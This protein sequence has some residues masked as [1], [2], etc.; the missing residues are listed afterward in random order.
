MALVFALA[1]LAHAVP[2]AAQAG[3]DV[4]LYCKTRC[5]NDY[6]GLDVCYAECIQ[7]QTATGAGQ[8][9]EQAAVDPNAVGTD[10]ARGHA[11]TLGGNYF[12][13]IGLYNIFPEDMARV[14]AAG[15]NLV[16]T[17]TSCCNDE[18]LDMH[19]H[20]LAEAERA[21][22]KVF[23]MPVYP[24]AR[25]LDADEQQIRILSRAVQRRS[26][27]PALM[28][29]FLFPQPGHASLPPEVVKKI[30]FFTGENDPAHPLAA[31]VALDSR[32][33]DYA[34]VADWLVAAP[35]P[36]PY[37]PID[38]VRGQVRSAVAAAA[39]ARPVLAMLQTHYDTS[40]FP[41]DF[42]NVRPSEDELYNMAHQAVANGAK[43]LIFWD[44]HG[45][46]VDVMRHI[47]AW[48]AL[49]RVAG[50]L[51]AHAPL[52]L[53]PDSGVSVGVAPAGAPV[54]VLLKEDID[55]WYL[56]AVNYR[57]SYYDITLDLSQ[58]N[59]TSVE[60]MPHYLRPELYVAPPVSEQAVSDI[61]PLQSYARDAYAQ[62]SGA[63][64]RLRKFQVQGRTLSFEMRP[65]DV[66]WFRIAKP[67]SVT[68]R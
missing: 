51:S 24:P 66:W 36:L 40:V 32:I 43:G 44:V 34:P 16:Y 22:L 50:D 52:F 19:Q 39:G 2:A 5:S 64:N 35:F 3:G 42:G 31:A 60:A 14:K 62:D 17:F 53:L 4:K 8:G 38:R 55:A 41:F 26:V 11:I 46:K 9:G 54:D 67:E 61:I 33:M 68:G 15:F 47:G 56:L 13:P 6:R 12:F 7:N 25:L 28:F 29:W 58:L 59:F 20:F 57:R 65:I 1:A 49:E 10:P 21:G 63:R 30:R 23:L 37:Y 45:D 18:E 27:S 48:P